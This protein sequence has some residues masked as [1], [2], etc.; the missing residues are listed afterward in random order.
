MISPEI[1]IEIEIFDEDD[2]GGDDDGGRVKE[3]ELQE[4]KRNVGSTCLEISFT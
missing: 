3:W 4:V 1:E 2:D